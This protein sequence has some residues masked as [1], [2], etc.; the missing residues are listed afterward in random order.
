[1]ETTQ[2]RIQRAWL[3]SKGWITNFD[4]SA[5]EIYLPNVPLDQ[6]PQAFLSLAEMTKDF[7][8]SVVTG[9]SG[10]QALSISTD[11]IQSN[12]ERLQTG[13]IEDLSVNFTA[14]VD[15]FSLDLHVIVR[16]LRNAMAGLEIVWW[17][18][19]AFTEGT[20]PFTQFQVVM[21][22]F[23]TLQELFKAQGLFIGSE[24]LEKPGPEAIQ[25][26]DV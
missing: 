10:E 20:D 3:R 8:T 6:I 18:D 16:L 14:P 24:N 2:S 12:L 5:T 4:G 13:A 7:R 25:W 19:Q 1:M 9:E 23:F 15:G 11:S 22:Y 17:S 21:E 26:I